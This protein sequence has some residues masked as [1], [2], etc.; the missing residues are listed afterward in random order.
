MIEGFV[1][2]RQF[3]SVARGINSENEKLANQLQKMHKEE[4]DRQAAA[5]EAEAVGSM[6]T[7]PMLP[8]PASITTSNSANST[9]TGHPSGAPLATKGP[10]EQSTSSSSNQSG[11]EQQK[12]PEPPPPAH[13]TVPV[14]WSFIAP[15]RY[16]SGGLVAAAWCMDQ[17]QR[18]LTLPIMAKHFPR[19]FARMIY[20]SFSAHDEHEPDIE[21][22]DG[23]LFWP[24]QLVTGQGLGWACTMGKA[25]IKEFGKEFG[26]RGIDGIIPKPDAE[27]ADGDAATPAGAP[28][29]AST[30]V[31]FHDSD[32]PNTVPR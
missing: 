13:I 9:P 22:D 29:Q 6:A 19:T 14:N 23:E 28:V 5:K 18:T 7:P 32:G 27:G 20:S 10:A 26:Y 12:K 16:Q 17:S 25:M 15:R 8:S 11:Q 31:P 1:H 21:D 30:P 2:G 4:L 3:N 24:G